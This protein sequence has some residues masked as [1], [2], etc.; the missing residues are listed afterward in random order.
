MFLSLVL[1][2]RN[3]IY[4]VPELFIWLLYTWPSSEALQIFFFVHTVQK[5]QF[6]ICGLFSPLVMGT[7][8][9]P[10]VLT[11]LFSLRQLSLSLWWLP[12]LFSFT[13]AAIIW[14]LSFPRLRSCLL[15]LELRSLLK[16]KW[17]VLYLSKIFPYFV[18][19]KQTKEER[20]VGGCG[21]K[22]SWSWP[23]SL[24]QIPPVTKTSW[25]LTTEREAGPHQT[26]W[27]PF[28]DLP[29]TVEASH[30]NY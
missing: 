30:I 3:Q 17:K 1:L 29:L 8:S 23:V 5:C 4:S 10:N 7:Q 18:G 27:F 11:L 9:P 28:S 20:L 26:T 14:M 24:S 21:W 15:P 19:K 22:Y 25:H 12:P 13:G 2:L 6:H 16:P